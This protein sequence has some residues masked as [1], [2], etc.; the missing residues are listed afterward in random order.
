MNQK[1]IKYFD[2]YI[3]IHIISSILNEED[4][5]LVI[6]EVINNKLFEKTDTEKE[7]FDSIE[8]LKFPQQYEDGGIIIPDDLNEKEKNDPRVEA[9]FKRYRHNYLSTFIS[10]QDYYELPKRTIRASGNICHI[11]KPI[12]FRDFQNLYQDKASMDMTLDEFKYLTSTCWNEKYQPFTI[13]MTRDAY[14]GC[15]S[16]GLKTIFVPDSTPFQIKN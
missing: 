8:E 10:S 2:N 13:D 14:D 5:D 9:M 4:I 1:L 16:L 7:T 6:E 3:R 12:N 15:Y 11:F